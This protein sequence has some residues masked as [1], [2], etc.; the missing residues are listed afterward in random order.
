MDDQQVGAPKLSIQDI[1]SQFPQY[2]DMSDDKLADALHEKYYADMPRDQFN[3]S[4]GFTPEPFDLEK[5]AA[6]NRENAWGNIKAAGRGV[7]EG[8]EG[9]AGLPG[10]VERLV[11]EGVKYVGGK[12]GLKAPTGPE[13]HTLPSSEDIGKV[14][15]NVTGKFDTESEN[16]LQKDLHSV[17]SFLPYVL[18]PEAA[19]LKKGAR[20]AIGGVV[21]NPIA[22]TS[23][24]A[25]A[26]RVG[27]AVAGGVGAEEA[28]E[29]A[30]GTG[31][32]TAARI[33]GGM[34]GGAFAG[35][36]EKM[37][38]DRD[39]KGLLKASDEIKAA[40]QAGYK[41]LEQNPTT[42]HPGAVNNFHM[43][44]DTAFNQRWF[45]EVTAPATYRTMRDFERARDRWTI[46][47][48]MGQYER[49]G[50]VV[51][52]G[53]ISAQDAEAARLLRGEII[54]W[55]DSN[56][57]GVKPQI[58]EALGNWSAHKKIEELT[59]AIEVALHR[60]HVSGTG[61]NTQN[62]IRQEVRKIIDNDAKR[63]GYPP[64]VVAQLQK[65]ADGTITQNM[66][67][68]V[69]RFAPTGLHSSAFTLALALHSAPYAAAS[70]GLG[71]GGKKLGDYLTHRGVEEAIISLEEGAPANASATARRQNVMERV[72]GLPAQ[73]AARGA[74]AATNEERTRDDALEHAQP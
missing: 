32:E 14:R 38:A 26:T 28:S 1:R 42:I 65:V 15:E 59:K 35:K 3:N 72:G 66:A 63:R 62:T 9:I 19:V 33:V 67:R 6:K 7:V 54:D 49:L 11:G 39:T 29:A 36:I 23:K 55:L 34:A 24:D 8:A 43:V 61:A 22:A 53:T 56:V 5:M 27:G 60:A 21:T 37:L 4:I 16:H 58:K 20:N 69:G 25:L 52:G 50:K 73:G 44:M 51:P 13:R 71:Y 2:G 70:A 30:E 17:G 57:Q 64:N 31:H 18:Q 40:S 41:I 74:V 48:V 10:D 45:S 68:F 12:M 47:D 46:G